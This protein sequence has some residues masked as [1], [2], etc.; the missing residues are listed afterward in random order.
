M[1][2]SG[3]NSFVH[4]SLENL[5]NSWQLYV[6][7]CAMNDSSTYWASWNYSDNLLFRYNGS[8]F[9]PS[10]WATED[11]QGWDFCKVYNKL[12]LVLFCCCD[13]IVRQKATLFLLTL[14]GHSPL[15]RVWSQNHRGMLLIGLL[16]N[17][18]LA[19]FPV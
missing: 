7:K 12:A 3:V 2:I 11:W 6:F 19:S 9:D 18:V 1:L 5:N 16:T 10:N 15:L 8:L 13:K 14:S 17:S 4:N